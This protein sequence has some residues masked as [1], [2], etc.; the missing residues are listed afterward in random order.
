M[1]RMD[2]KDKKW[3]AIEAMGIQYES[4]VIK[5]HNRSFELYKRQSKLYTGL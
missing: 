2:E 4:Q 1:R 5:D 3:A